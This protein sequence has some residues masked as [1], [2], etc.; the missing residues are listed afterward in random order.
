M[1]GLLVHST[2]IVVLYSSEKRWGEYSTIG[3][4]YNGSDKRHHNHGGNVTAVKHPSE[5]HD[6]D[7]PRSSLKKLVPNEIYLKI[8]SPIKLDG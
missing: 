7:C 5:L 2:E 3:V 1:I 6:V 8:L 4:P